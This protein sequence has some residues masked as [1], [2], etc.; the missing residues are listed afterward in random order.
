MTDFQRNPR[1]YAI[2]LVE[3]GLVDPILMLTAALKWMSTDDVRD[4]LAANE[5]F[6]EEDDEDDVDQEWTPDNADFN[7]VGSRHH[8]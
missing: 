3:D 4:M 6:F 2:Q 1:D 5:L 8:Y 7:D